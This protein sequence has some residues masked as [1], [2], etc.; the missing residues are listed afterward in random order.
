MSSEYNLLEKDSENEEQNL[1]NN[2][3][4]DE[5]DEDENSVKA[6]DENRL[7][8]SAMTE[9]YSEILNSPLFADSEIPEQQIDIRKRRPTSLS[10]KQSS[11]CTFPFSFRQ[12]ICPKQVFISILASFPHGSVRV[13]ESNITHF[14]ADDLEYK[15]KIASPS[16]N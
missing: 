7:A 6:A 16:G 12:S 3:D 15:I 2:D 9:S 10:R 13:D 14:V 1:E 5:D 11:Q 4:D 8:K